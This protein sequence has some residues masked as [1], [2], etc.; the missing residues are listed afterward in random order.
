MTG[1][2]VLTIFFFKEFDQKFEIQKYPRLSFSQ[3]L[4]AGAS[5]EYQIWH[6][7]L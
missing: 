1:S 2:G 7:C 4:E 5:W 6:E 3:Y